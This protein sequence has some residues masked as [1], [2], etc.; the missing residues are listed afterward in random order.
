MK[1]IFLFILICLLVNIS[2]SQT[3]NFTFSTSDFSIVE[4]NGK[5]MIDY[6][7]GFNA[8]GNACNPILPSCV[9]NILLPPNKKVSNYIVTYT[10]TSWQNDIVLEAVPMEHPT[11]GGNYVDS[12]CIYD[13]KV[14]PDSI[15]RNAG[16]CT[17][18]HYQYISFLITPFIY[19]AMNGSLSIV[20]TVNISIELVDDVI[21][22]VM[23][24]QSHI[25]KRVVHNLED[26][27]LFYSGTEQITSTPNIDYLII[28]V[29]SLKNSF[30]P[31]RIWKTQKGVYTK[32][33]TLEEIYT[34]YNGATQ[35]LCIKQC[36][37]DYYDNYGLKWLL[38]GGDNI[39]VPSIEAYTTYSDYTALI[40]SDIFYGCFDGTYNWDGNGN[41]V[42]GELTDNVTFNQV[43]NISRLPIRTN[44]Q[45]E[46]YVNKLLQYEKNPIMDQPSMLVCARKLGGY[47][48]GESDAHIKS[49]IFID[50]YIAPYWNNGY[51]LR[52]YDTFTDFI[53]GANY[54]LNSINLT[55]QLNND[56]N[57]L[58]FSTHGSSNSWSLE[59]GSYLSNHVEMLTN[60]NPLLI[61]TT[62]CHTNAFDQSDPCLSEAFIRKAGGG[63]IAYLG[64]SRYGWY[65]SNFTTLGSSFQINAMFFKNLFEGQSH[66]FSEI[67][68][69]VKL[70]F[71]GE[72][73]TDKN[74]F[75]WL[76]LSNN[77]IGDAE[78][79]IYTTIPNKFEHVVLT[80]NGTNL[81]INVDNVDSCTLTV[82]NIANGGN[83]YSTYT[84]TSSATFTDVPNDYTLVITKDNYVPYIIQQ[85]CYIANKIID[86]NQVIEGC[87]ETQI[88]DVITIPVIPVTQTTDIGVLSEEEITASSSDLQPLGSVTITSS[89]A[90][91][92]HNGGI[93][94]IMQLNMEEGAELYIH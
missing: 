66:H 60:R 67:I 17:I 47:Q 13:L 49:N 11:D 53:T 44:Q 74:T 51:R 82:S 79:P 21:S 40:P 38:L 39:I 12:P 63:A 5:H 25:I 85:D 68:K 61:V 9:K 27:D 41:G 29:D 19:N 62:A 83:Y 80:R 4:N 30:E 71:K 86:K 45:I 91:E 18:D 1:R 46:I 94:K 34:E 72:A 3:Y 69:L 73:N 16:S 8:I 55:N 33:I 89:G 84:N 58:H 64:S 43:V 76:L 6:P 92:I 87:L 93:V 15:V 56:Y 81:I 20:N 54:Q 88:G 52:F 26:V 24:T 90:L 22:N 2:Y 57:F 28:T 70:H 75:R 77:A 50:Q 35:E 42:I 65:R 59:I 10:T 23:P 7:A 78:L 48:N 32:I 31:L 37:E 36:V 14:Y